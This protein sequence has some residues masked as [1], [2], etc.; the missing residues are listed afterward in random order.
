M[1]EIDSYENITMACRQCTI[2]TSIAKWKTAHP[3]NEMAASGVLWFLHFFCCRHFMLTVI[4]QPATRAIKQSVW[5]F[6]ML[7]FDNF[8]KILSTKKAKD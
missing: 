8:P 3:Y 4:C 5:K 1:P 2:T 6:D 7:T